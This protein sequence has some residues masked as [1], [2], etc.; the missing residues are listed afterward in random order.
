MLLIL[1][2]SLD[3]LAQ[4]DDKKIFST[5]SGAVEFL[6]NPFLTQRVFTIL[7]WL[8]PNNFFSR[9]DIEKGQF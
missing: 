2:F 6:F 7:V 3:F 5:P 9:E 1:K 4:F 8:M